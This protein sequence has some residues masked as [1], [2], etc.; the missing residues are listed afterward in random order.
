MKLVTGFLFLLV[1]I[2]LSFTSI[3]IIRATSHPTPIGPEVDGWKVG[4]CYQMHHD[5][6]FEPNPIVRKILDHKG[7][8]LKYVYFNINT[9]LGWGI[10]DSDLDHWRD[11][12]TEVPCPKT[13]LEK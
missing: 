9:V 10:E 5:N 11:M 12:Y 6:P 8:Y 2:A 1:V 7:K 13:W 3:A 4:A